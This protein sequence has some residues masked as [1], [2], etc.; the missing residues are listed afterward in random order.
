MINRLTTRILLVC[1]V[2]A[3]SACDQIRS[4]LH[5]MPNQDEQQCLN[6][7]R[8]NFKDPDVLFVANL[9]SRGLPEKQGQYWVRYKA[10][11][12]YGAFL[13]GNML[14]EKNSATGEWE[15]AKVDDILLVEELITNLLEA[16]VEK[17]KLDKTY[18]S[19]FYKN[20]DDSQIDARARREAEE[21]IFASP[22][23]LKQYFLTR[24][25]QGSTSAPIHRS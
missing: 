9:G 8:L 6:S 16:E 21:I 14:C 13:Q 18:K 5:M 7:E 11:N 10:K 3:L 17:R 4:T 24:P 23:D 1:A 15:K 19:R 20:G 25:G 2:C 12:S 22:K